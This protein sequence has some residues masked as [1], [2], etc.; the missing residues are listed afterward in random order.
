MPLKENLFQVE[1][2][3][4]NYFDNWPHRFPLIIRVL[5][6]TLIAVAG[7]QLFSKVSYAVGP[8]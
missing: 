2:N 5:V 7:V 1:Q 8:Y 3:T 4:T 6:G